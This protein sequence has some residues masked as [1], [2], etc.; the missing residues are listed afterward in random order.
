MAWRSV[1]ITQPSR[2]SLK[3]KMLR[4]QQDDGDVTVPLEDMAALVIEHAQ[5]ALTS[6]LLSACAECQIAVITVDETH[7][8]NGVLLPHQL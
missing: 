1:M 4:V 5:I 8:P 3:N 6:Q 7:H 2:L